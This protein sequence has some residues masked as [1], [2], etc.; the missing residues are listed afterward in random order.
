[1]SDTFTKHIPGSIQPCIGEKKVCVRFADGTI[2]FNLAGRLN[3]ERCG[4][5]SIIEWRFADQGGHHPDLTRPIVPC[6]CCS[7]TGK[8][9]LGGDLW[10]TLQRLDSTPRTT[11]ELQEPG[12]TRNAINNRLIALEA[13]GLAV[14][15]GKQSKWRLWI[16]TTTNAITA[17]TLKP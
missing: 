15:V 17:T 14:S 9:T 3:W 10:S 6:G 12:I 13:H 5:D 2:N 16:A 1:M 8:V 4:Q 7:G 11:A